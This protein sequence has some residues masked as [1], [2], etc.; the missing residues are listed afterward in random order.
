MTKVSS[1]RKPSRTSIARASII[2]TTTGILLWSML[3]VTGCRENQR[4]SAEANIEREDIPPPSFQ[5]KLVE[6]N[7]PRSE[8][9]GINSSGL[10]VGKMG[11][12]GGFD[13]A[14]V[15]TQSGTFTLCP[16]NEGASSASDINNEGVATVWVATKTSG[17]VRS[18][19]ASNR[20]RQFLATPTNGEAMANA[21]NNTGLVVGT[22][23][24]ANGKRSAAFWEKPYSGFS[25]LPDLGGVAGAAI[26][27]NDRGQIAGWSET[28]PGKPVGAVWVKGEV[29]NLGNLHDGGFSEARGINAKGDVVGF[30]S[31]GTDGEL[32]AVLW[33]D[34]TII[35]LGT[36]G[37]KSSYANAIN[38]NGIIV[39][40]SDTKNG[41]QVATVWVNDRM[42]DLNELTE[43]LECHLEEAHAINTHGNIA[44][45][46]TINGISRRG[47]VLIMD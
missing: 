22:I 46:G 21:I 35:D 41:K 25:A 24:N 12:I 11:P 27:V 5:M 43:S 29:V 7:Q 14:F 34:G 19:L 31:L 26:D 28:G 38:D 39:G 10:V 2:L 36:L 42:Y 45:T 20:G 30:A 6:T 9:R 1:N 3:P 33:R 44:C 16:L 15:D 37:G 47:V 23:I 4:V 40:W 13:Y 8:P 18:F 17:K 32:H